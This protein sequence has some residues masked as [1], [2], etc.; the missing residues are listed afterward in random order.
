[1]SQDADTIRQWQDAFNAFMR[2]ELSSEGYAEGFDPEIELIW[3]D[4]QTYPD[5][6]QHLSGLPRCVAFSE[7]YR[8]SWL[9]LVQEPLE[10]IEAP[11]DHVVAFI[12]QSG[13]GRQSG[14]PIVIHFFALCAIRDGKVRRIEYFRH[15]ADA[16]EAAGLAD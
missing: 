6:P 14:V 7:Q 1:M 10:L 4:R 16:I 15:R 3:R 9:D 8:D 11:E 12:R 5:F 13:R 2:G